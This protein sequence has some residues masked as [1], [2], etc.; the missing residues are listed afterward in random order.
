MIRSVPKS[1][2]SSVV[3]LTT[4]PVISDHITSNAWIIVNN[5]LKRTWT[6]EDV[7]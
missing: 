4:P 5:V 1:Y 3:Y 6:D 2:G 7:A